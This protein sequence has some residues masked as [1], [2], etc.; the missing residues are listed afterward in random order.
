LYGEIV[1]EW[2]KNGSEFELDV[3]IPPN[4]TA[5]VFLPATRNQEVTENGKKVVVTWLNDSAVIKIGSGKYR[6]KIKNVK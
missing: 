6:F 4:T 5:T 3:E 2:E 1:S